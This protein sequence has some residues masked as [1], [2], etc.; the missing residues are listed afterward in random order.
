MDA[1]SLFPLFAGLKL[2]RR[3]L[4]HSWVL[5]MLGRPLDRESILLLSAIQSDFSQTELIDLCE[6]GGPQHRYYALQHI[7]AAP[8][9]HFLSLRRLVDTA[10]SRGE[11]DLVRQLLMSDPV[12]R[13]PDPRLIRYRKEML[14]KLPVA[15]SPS[16]GRKSG[17]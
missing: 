3:M 13:S 8:G 17:R 12:R 16:S 4:P 14:Q 2:S 1:A 10:Q 7:F 11:A 15:G 6:K 5:E 9:E